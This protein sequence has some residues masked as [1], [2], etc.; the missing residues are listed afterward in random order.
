M[1]WRELLLHGQPRP[2]GHVTGGPADAVVFTDGS[3]DED[4]G[5]PHVGGAL[6]AWW[7]ESPIGFSAEVPMSLVRRWIPRKSQIALIELLA[8]VAAL[9]RYGPMLTGKRVTFLVDSE[10]ALD[11]LI[12]GYSKSEDCCEL[13][14]TF[15]NLAAEYQVVA[16]LDRVSTDANVSDGL[17][18]RDNEPY[19]K[20]GW[21]VHN[22]DLEGMFGRDTGHDR[23]RALRN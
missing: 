23:F 14:C 9:E 16:Y 8:V 21:E 15:W 20:A 12:K 2:L 22:I 5:R 10:C 19:R 7:L 6:L 13:V 17:S 3:T 18:R 1:G 4:G 11:A